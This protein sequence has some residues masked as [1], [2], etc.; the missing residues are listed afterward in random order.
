MRIYLAGRYSRRRELQQYGKRLEA[1]GHRIVS[2]WVDGHHESRPNVDA[3]ATDEERGMWADEDLTDIEI[4]DLL[5]LF[6]EK[7][8][9]GYSRGGR[10]GE[11]GYALG[12]RKDVIVVGPRENVFCCL[13]EVT[14]FTTFAECLAAQAPVEATR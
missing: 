7:E 14:Q 11:M 5:I 1:A 4:A 9:I 10:F 3:T 12:R 13:W 8:S 2:S 6:T